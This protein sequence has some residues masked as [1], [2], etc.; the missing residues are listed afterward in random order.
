MF[1]AKI[2]VLAEIL[3]RDY[4][5]FSPQKSDVI[6]RLKQINSLRKKFAHYRRVGESKHSDAKLTLEYFKDGILTKEDVSA[7]FIK[8]RTYQ[9][10]DIRLTL[11]RIL[12]Q[13]SKGKPNL[14]PRVKGKAI[15]L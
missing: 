15:S 8:S 3:K 10:F 5:A 13:V 9:A 12:H 14:L 11:W 1:G 6:Q 7:V 4:P 2:D